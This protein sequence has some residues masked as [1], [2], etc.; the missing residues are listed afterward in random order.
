MQTIFRAQSPAVINGKMK[1]E[2]F[3]FDFAPDRT[4][5]VLAETAKISAKAGK[6]K[7]NDK[8][9]LGDFLNFCPV[10]SFH[11]AQM[12]PINVDHMMQQLK[13]VYVDRVVRNGFEDVYLYNDRLLQLDHVELEKFAHLRDII[14]QTKAMK[15]PDQVDVN[16]QGF[17]NEEYEEIERL[18]KKPKAQLTVEDLEKLKEVDEKKKQRNTAISILRGI[19]IRMPM[20]LFGA[21]IIDEKTEITLDNFTDLVDDQSWEEFMPK[22]VTKDL[23]REFIPYYDEDI[24]AA[25]RALFR[26]FPSPPGAGIR[27][28]GVSAGNLCTEGE[29]SLFDD[30]EKK[31]KLYGAIDQLKSRFGESILTRAALTKPR[32][33]P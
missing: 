4:L 10:I 7:S 3:V 1:E 22:G 9:I 12:A 32:E 28:L 16:K 5:K 20:I 6:A 13:R 25:A 24:F 2:C 30:H 33:E 8:V 14:G 26:A 27:L 17:T 15:R 29:L 23:F 11:G 18:K 21:D 31:E 19:S